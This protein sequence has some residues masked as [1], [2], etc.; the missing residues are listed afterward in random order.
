MTV[1]ACY[2]P[3]VSAGATLLHYCAT[4]LPRSAGPTPL[5]QSRSAHSIPVYPHTLAAC[6][7]LLLPGLTLAAPSTLDA[8]ADVR[9][10]RVARPWAPAYLFGAA[11]GTAAGGGGGGGGGGVDELV[12][13]QLSG[14][15]EY[16][17]HVIN[18]F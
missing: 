17:R 15:A 5:L 10:E 9:M 2:T 3:R 4:P 16:A 14:L 13:Q 12:A 7:S 11:R 6:S 1:R 8:Q 18:A